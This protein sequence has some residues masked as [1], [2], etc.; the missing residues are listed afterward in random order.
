MTTITEEDI[1]QKA[2]FKVG[3]VITHYVG[4]IAFAEGV[5]VGIELAVPAG[6]C[7][8]GVGGVKIRVMHL[9][10]DKTSFF[11]F[12]L[13]CYLCTKLHKIVHRSSND[14]F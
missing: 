8:V 13:N 4:E 1:G 10:T 6:I 7:Y 12:E 2:T 5:W 14:I 3:K 9:V 11:P